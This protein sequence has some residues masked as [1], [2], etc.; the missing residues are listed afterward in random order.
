MKRKVFF[1]VLAL[2][3]IAAGLMS[4]NLVSAQDSTGANSMVAAIA[5]KFNLNQ[6]D[7]QT[8]FDEQR[9]KHQAEMKTQMES[10]LTQ[11]VADGK[12]TEAQ[13]Q[14]I[15]THFTQTKEGRPNFGEFKNLTAEQRHTKMEEKRKETDS[16]LSQNGLTHET[17]QEIMGHKGGMGGRK[18]FMH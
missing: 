15:L 10:K 3:I 12:I 9:S 2:A 1:P 17:L 16:F 18:M 5:Q 13:K 11:A 8:V 7:V 14:A 6:S 4:T